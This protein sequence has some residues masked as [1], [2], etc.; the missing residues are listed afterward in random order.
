MAN[1]DLNARPIH[2]LKPMA[3]I[4]LAQQ[5]LQ[6][7]FSFE[8]LSEDHFRY[9]SFR[10]SNFL[11]FRAHYLGPPA[12]ITSSVYGG[13]LFSQALAVAERTVDAIFLPHATHSFFILNGK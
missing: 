6:K 10:I 8:K 2:D 4:D 13:L 12:L 1:S 11:K 3:Q 7:L 5:Y 9:S